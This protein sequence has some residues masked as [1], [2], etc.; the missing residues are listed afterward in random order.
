MN[1]QLNYGN[2]RSNMGTKKR[3]VHVFEYNNLVNINK[4][5]RITS[6]N[7]PSQRTDK[8][9]LESSLDFE[10]DESINNMNKVMMSQ[11]LSGNDIFSRNFYSKYNSSGIKPGKIK[12]K[13]IIKGLKFSSSKKKF[14]NK[15]TFLV[16]LLE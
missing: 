9:H 1:A 10:K 2:I 13:S 14:T 11:R 3:K 15:S 8:T 5:M 4:K 16:I 7:K 6:L 12:K